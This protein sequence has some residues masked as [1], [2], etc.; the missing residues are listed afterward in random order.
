M[1]MANITGDHFKLEEDVKT[2]ANYVIQLTQR[3]SDL[4]LN[5]KNDVMLIQCATALLK[6][7]G[8]RISELEIKNDNEG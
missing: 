5:R 4:E 2:L 6:D 1:S 8:Q 7:Q 3:V